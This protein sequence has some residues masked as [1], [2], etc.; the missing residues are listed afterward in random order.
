[1]MRLPH[2]DVPAA[3]ALAPRLGLAA[4][5]DTGHPPWTPGAP[6]RMQA[7]SAGETAGAARRLDSQRPKA[8]RFPR[9]IVVPGVCRP[10]GKQPKMSGR[11]Y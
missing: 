5:T 9:L 7:H 3:V 4:R 6:G 8:G 11:G 2:E 1:M 10:L